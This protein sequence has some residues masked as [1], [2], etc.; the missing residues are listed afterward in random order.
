MLC[1]TSSAEPKPLLE[2]EGEEFRAR[3]VDVLTTKE[4]VIDEVGMREDA[5]LTKSPRVLNLT[6]SKSPKSKAKVP[7]GLY[8]R[9][10]ENIWRVI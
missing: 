10:L 8:K 1:Q 6:K 7:R 2:P 3:E 5:N 9:N 4:L